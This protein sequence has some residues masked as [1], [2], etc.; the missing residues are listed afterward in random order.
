[1][2]V[3]EP[4]SEPDHTGFPFGQRGQHGPQVGLSE[5]DEDRMSNHDA[6]DLRTSDYQDPV[7]CQNPLQVW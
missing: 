6:I 5:G 3:G 7:R 1:M 2:T 4:Q